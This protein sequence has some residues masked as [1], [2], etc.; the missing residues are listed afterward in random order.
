MNL[1]E[2]FDLWLKGFASRI[3]AHGIADGRVCD[4][5]NAD[6]PRSEAPPSRGEGA[7]G[8]ACQA[9]ADITEPPSWSG[10][11]TSA[12]GAPLLSPYAMLIQQTSEVVNES[13]IYSA[14]PGQGCKRFRDSLAN[15]LLPSMEASNTERSSTAMARGPSG[16]GRLLLR[17]SEGSGQALDILQ[18]AR[19]QLRSSGVTGISQ[20]SAGIGA[21]PSMHKYLLPLLVLVGLKVAVA[22]HIPQRRHPVTLSWSVDAAGRH[23][24][25]HVR[26]AH[27]GL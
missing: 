6:S 1:R 8:L 3:A 26:E 25:G 9:L 20:S 14:A 4:V 22:Q 10:R 12:V 23:A 13:T 15:T 5:A 18:L 19:A 24:E 17:A 21:L 16:Q 11:L 7:T 2:A 27:M